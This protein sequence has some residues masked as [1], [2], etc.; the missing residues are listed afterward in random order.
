MENRIYEAD[1]VF[2]QQFTI[3]IH[4]LKMSTAYKDTADYIACHRQTYAQGLPQGESF[5]MKN[6]H[7]MMSLTMISLSA[8]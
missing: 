7:D 5:S 3:A 6:I 2:A 4:L 1:I 8:S